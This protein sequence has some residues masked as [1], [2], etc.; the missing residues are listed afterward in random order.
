MSI[1]NKTVF[2]AIK[3]DFL[4]GA[5]DGDRLGILILVFSCCSFPQFLAPN[6]LYAAKWIKMH[7]YYSLTHID[8]VVKSYF[9]ICLIKKGLDGKQKMRSDLRER[10]EPPNI[11]HLCTQI[12]SDTDHEQP[13]MCK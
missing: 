1:K 10:A 6:S 3:H 13:Y 11:Q 12:Q 5:G 2:S 9:N 7:A 8:T 4:P